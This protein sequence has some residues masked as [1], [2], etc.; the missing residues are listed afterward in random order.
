[1]PWNPKA[2][3]IIDNLLS[4]SE[5]LKFEPSD[6]IEVLELI[7]EVLYLIRDDLLGEE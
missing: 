5:A 7:Q 4:R 6:N 3:D 2:I 1:M